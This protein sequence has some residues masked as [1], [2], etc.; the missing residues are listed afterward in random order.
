MN[1]FKFYIVFLLRSLLN[2][3]FIGNACNNYAAVLH[4]NK[5]NGFSNN[6]TEYNQ[7]LER[8]DFPISNNVQYTNDLSNVFNFC[9][10]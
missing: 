7:C 3:S 1:F 6:A 8:D 9:L 2:F 10:I 4:E 5:S